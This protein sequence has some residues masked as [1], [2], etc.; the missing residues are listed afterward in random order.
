M[1]KE[2]KELSKG[3]LMKLAQSL[4]IPQY[5]APNYERLIKECGTKL[6]KTIVLK[7][8]APIGGQKKVIEGMTLADIQKKAKDYKIPNRSI[9]G[10]AELVAKILEYEQ[11]P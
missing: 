9:M 1:S 6:K 5:T 3:E 2:T 11:A 7:E 4:K 10:R 8:S